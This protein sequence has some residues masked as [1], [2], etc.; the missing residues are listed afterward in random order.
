MIAMPLFRY[1]VYDR[2]ANYY[3]EV[4]TNHLHFEGGKFNGNRIKYDNEGKIYDVKIV[5]YEDTVQNLNKQEAEALKQ[6]RIEK[7]R[8]KVE[9]RERREA[10]ETWETYKIS[11]DCNRAAL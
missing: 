7:Y 8:A 11:E 4:D 9:E 5:M 1:T 3:H 6:A 10:H 2:E